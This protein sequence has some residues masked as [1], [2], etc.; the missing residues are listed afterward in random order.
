MLG[1]VGQRHI[2]FPH[3]LSMNPDI[4]ELMTLN[5]LSQP[6]GSSKHGCYGKSTPYASE[7]TEILMLASLHTIPG[8]AMGSVGLSDPAFNV[9]QI[10][11]PLPA[12]I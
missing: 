8:V 12:R 10:T 5:R 1:Q 4:V 3:Y 7:K 11:G 9:F 2:S 6:A